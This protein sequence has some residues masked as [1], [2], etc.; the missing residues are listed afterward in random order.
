MILGPG[1]GAAT[2]ANPLV[3]VGADVAATIEQLNGW[4]RRVEGAIN[5]NRAAT[6][7][8]QTQVN[9]TQ[10]ALMGMVDQ[11]KT[12]LEG[13]VS[14]L[15]GEVKALRAQT[16]SSQQQ[17]A[18]LR[19][20]AEAAEDRF[21]GI[22]ESLRQLVGALEQRLG[23]LD[24]QLRSGGARL[25]GL[26]AG[27]PS[28]LGVL[29]VPGQA[30]RRPEIGAPGTA[31]ILEVQRHTVAEP[32]AARRMYF[33]SQGGRVFTKLGPEM[34]APWPMG[35]R[36]PFDTTAARGIAA[37]SETAA[38]NVIPQAHLIAAAHGTPAANAILAA[39][40]HGTAAAH[41]TVAA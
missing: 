40:E 23:Q 39:H 16:M 35:R 30:K 31:F 3:P 37:G 4:S 19:G 28:P 38:A 12:T 9:S 33:Y 17:T 21:C 24:A 25:D 18:R 10:A 15:R 5:E 13:I 41:G 11:A 20:R 29:R 34:G 27:M 2:D 7:P 8:L 1:F 32:P 14:E 22:E 26:V 6:E 36:S